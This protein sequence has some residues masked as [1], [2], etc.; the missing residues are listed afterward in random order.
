MSRPATHDDIRD[1]E[2]KPIVLITIIPTVFMEYPTLGLHLAGALVDALS[3]GLILTPDGEIARERTADE[4]DASLSAAQD[5]WDRGES[6]YLEALDGNL[7]KYRYAM[8]DYCRSERFEIL[9]AIPAPVS[10]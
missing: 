9:P 10:P 4:L 7:P 5:K 2:R 1:Y 6:D 8:D 3:L